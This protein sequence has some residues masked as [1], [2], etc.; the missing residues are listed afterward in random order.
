MARL[1][2]LGI[3]TLIIMSLLFGV[4]ISAFA[5]G[6]DFSGVLVTV[7]SGDTIWSIAKQY[8]PDKNI[9]KIMYEI[10]NVNGIKKSIIYPGQQLIIPQY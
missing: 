8:H 6:D 1:F 9:N 2:L 3:I 10:E 4:I 5:A 7:E